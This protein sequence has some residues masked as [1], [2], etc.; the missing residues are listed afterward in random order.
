MSDRAK[1]YDVTLLWGLSTPHLDPWEMARAYSSIC[2]LLRDDGIMAM[3]EIDRIFSIFY[4]MGYKDFLTEG[5]SGGVIIASAHVGYDERRGT[6]KRA[7]YTLP[8]FREVAK[9]NYRFWDLAGVSAMGWL[10]FKD[11]DLIPPSSHKI[12]GLRYIILLKEPRR[13][14]SPEMLKEDPKLL[15]VQ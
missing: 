14:I 4:K 3:D 11:L 12:Q 1:Y 13:K 6:F 5:E 8:G 2:H 10:F 15:H 7:T 9:L